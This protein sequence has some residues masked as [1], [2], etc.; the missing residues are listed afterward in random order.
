MQEDP[1]MR[2]VVC[3][4]LAR[5]GPDAMEAV[6]ALIEALEDECSTE[7]PEWCAIERS[8]LTR[9]LRSITGQEFGPDAAAWR[10]WW[11]AQS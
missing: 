9:A 6:P 5:I 8:S 7:R 11:E 2:W 3:E 4:G 10:A 1:G